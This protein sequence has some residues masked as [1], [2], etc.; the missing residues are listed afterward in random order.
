MNDIY[1]TR[2]CFHIPEECSEE[3][4]TQCPHDCGNGRNKLDVSNWLETI[5][6][7]GSEKKLVEIRFKNT[8]KAYYINN[9]DIPL[10]KGDIVAVEASPGHD[11]GV[12]SLVGDLVPLQMKRNGVP[13]SELKKIYRKA[14]ANDVEKW[15]QAIEKEKETMSTA[16]R[17]VST[18]N[19]SMKISDV[20]YQGDKTK[21]TFYY[22]SDD[23]VDFR[24]LIKD[25]AEHFKARIEMKQI[26]ARQEAGKVGGI[27]T[28]GR[29][30]CC[31][32]WMSSFVSVSTNA[33]RYQ[34]MSLNPQKLAGQ[35]GK[36]KCCL[37]YEMKCYMEA[38][39][40]FPDLTLPLETEQGTIYHSKTDIFRRIVWYSFG[41]GKEDNALIPLDV[42]VVK[43][44]IRLNRQG[45]KVKE[46]T[47]NESAHPAKPVDISYQNAVGEDSISRFEEKRRRKK[48]RNG[49]DYGKGGAN[50]GTFNNK[51]QKPQQKTESNEQRPQNADK[52]S[53]RRNNNSR[54][55]NNNRNRPNPGIGKPQPPIQK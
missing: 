51:V 27:G 14:K 15:F 38:Q 25:F 37:N 33:A 39:R 46:L 41:K 17:M 42:N 40:D 53:I 30:L 5:P 18:L 28:C 19:L 6:N 44:I 1:I 43:E 50:R 45:I 13:A 23:R 47:V 52:N 9:T 35:C 49:N 36:L 31:S 29:E 3:H 7:D 21:I 12:V 34:D 22:I 10:V 26:G 4:N 48:K 24:Q 16:R 2:G 20:E 8:R 54:S 32:K 11:I 55:R